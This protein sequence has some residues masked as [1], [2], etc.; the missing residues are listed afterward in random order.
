MD[1]NLSRAVTEGFCKFHEDGLLYRDTRLVNWSC[2]LRSTIS[3]I[4]VR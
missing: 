4:E 2:A 1:D 3:D